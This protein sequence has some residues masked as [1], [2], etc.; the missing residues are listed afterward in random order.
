MTDG[1]CLR[2]KE[3]HIKTPFCMNWEPIAAPVSAEPV[4]AGCLYHAGES[5][6]NG[7]PQTS[8]GEVEARPEQTLE[9]E[10]VELIGSALD[11]RDIP[12]LIADFIQWRDGA[13]KSVS[14]WLSSGH[15]VLRGENLRL[16]KELADAR[17][18]TEALRAERDAARAAALEE[19][20]KLGDKESAAS[21]GIDP[22][23]VT[24]WER[25]WVSSARHYAEAIRALITQPQSDALKVR[26]AR[27]VEPYKAVTTEI[28]RIDKFPEKYAIAGSM[29]FR[30]LVDMALAAQAQGKE[31]K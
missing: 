22:E 9:Q 13:A 20:A 10:I 29:Y 1:T 16:E 24:G 6:E 21:E 3:P 15:V 25:A 28:L 27:L 8:F 31:G 4:S 5:D 14:D 17:T 23:D 7:N 11:R 19:A 18:H 2:V 26:D 30:V 12:K